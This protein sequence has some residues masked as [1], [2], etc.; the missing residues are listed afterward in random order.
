MRIAI[1]G[2]PHWCEYSSI[3]RKQGKKYSIRLENLIQSINWVEDLSNRMLC[4][5]IVNLGDF[6]DKSELNSSEI[7]A[8]KE[9]K[10]NKNIH[11]YHIVG[12]HEMGRSDLSNSS[13]HLFASFPNCTVVDTPMSFAYDTLELSFI[14]YILEDNRKDSIACYMNMKTSR[15]IIFMHNDI[16]GI[17]M[18]RFISKAGFDKN[19]IEENCDMC[20]NGHLHNGLYITNKILNVGNLTGQ[21]FSEDASRYSHGAYIYDTD[22]NSIEFYENPYAF[23]FYK[24]DLTQGD[25]ITNIKENAVCTVKCF[26]DQVPQVYENIKSNSNIVESRLITYNRE[27]V[28]ES[29]FEDTFSVDHIK[30]F[31]DYILENFGTD[32]VVAQELTEVCR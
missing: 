14:P 27:V 7:T 19:D 1:Y 21:N 26:A 8:L 15:R 12:N 30:Q 4:D 16:Q 24:I 10:W 28:S 32:E 11:H 29:S 31:Q 23:N 25:W 5:I 17:N 3:I 2:D 9:I 22:A 6:F 13:S 20:F 18:G